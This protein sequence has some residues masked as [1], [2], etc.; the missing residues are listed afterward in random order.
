MSNKGRLSDKNIRNN[1]HRI[2][3]DCYAIKKNVCL[4][5]YNTDLPD[6]SHAFQPPRHPVHEIRVQRREGLGARHDQ[7]HPPVQHQTRTATTYIFTRR[8]DGGEND[9][10]FILS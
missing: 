3:N 5:R 2:S 1:M 10:L 4:I 7:A 6:Y 8:V 9:V